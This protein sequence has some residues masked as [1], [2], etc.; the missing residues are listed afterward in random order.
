MC[1]S[2]SLFLTL[3]SSFWVFS[4]LGLE[5]FPLDQQVLLIH[6]NHADRAG[7]PIP[8]FILWEARLQTLPSTGAS[9]HWRH[10]LILTSRDKALG[11]LKDG[12]EAPQGRLLHSGELQSSEL[13]PTA[14]QC[15]DLGRSHKSI[16]PAVW[17]RQNCGC[18]I[19]N[20]QG[21]PQKSCVMKE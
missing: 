12:L 18:F 6:G 14:A 4:K 9:D 10:C 21:W 11:H 16:W 2:L 17:N 8:F 5:E 7:L 19:F 15:L 1:V 13:L 20:E 3:I